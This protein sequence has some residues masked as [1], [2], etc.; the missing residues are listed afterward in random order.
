MRSVRRITRDGAV[1]RLAHYGNRARQAAVNVLETG[2]VSGVRSKHPADF[3]NFVARQAGR[4][5][6]G[7][8]DQWRVNEG[9]RFSSPAKIAVVLNCFYVDLLEELLER[10]TLIPVPFDLFVTNVSG[11]EVEVPQ[12]LGQMANSVVLDCENRGRDIL[13]MI[14]LINSGSLDHY[15]LILKVHTK[16]SPWRAEHAVLQGSGEQWRNSFLEELLPSTEG[17]KTILAAF[18]QDSNLGL[19]TASGNIVGPEHWGGDQRIVEQ[20]LRRIELSVRPDE[21]RFPG[22]SMYWCRGFVLQGLRSLNLIRQDFDEEAGQIDGTTAHAVE[23]IIGIL[24]SEAGL[25][26]TYPSELDPQVSPDQGLDCW[27]PGTEMGARA[28]VV[29]FYLPQFHPSEHNNV[30]WG[31]GFT[32][33][34]NVAGAAPNYAG[35]YQPRIPTELGFYDLRLDEVRHKQL[36]LARQHCVAGFMYYYYW[37]S[38]E[39][40]L[41]VPIE[42]L[43]ADKDLD[44]PFCLMWANENWT[45]RWDG[46]SADVLIGQDYERVPAEDFIDDVM[47]F[48]LDPRYMRVEG[49]AVLAVYRPGQMSNFGEVALEW[50]RRAKQA[51]VGELLLLSVDVAK[52]FDAID[53]QSRG[54]VDGILEFP[55]H[56]LPWRVGP[57]MEA[58]LDKRWR[59]NFMSYQATAQASI[60][61]A[62]EIPDTYYPGAMVSFDNTARRQWHP[63]VWYGSNPYTFRRWVGSQ[64]QVLAARP[65]E[66]RLLFI[67]A[68]N[69]WAESAVLEPTTRYGRTFLLAIR[70]AVWE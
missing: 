53:E 63:D 52:D 26:M 57:T 69:E 18:A 50:R 45:R 68:W 15:S 56:G 17:V 33:W 10:L 9:L 14:S 35:H 6:S 51:G 30:W 7:F 16:K 64:A 24:T 66:Q 36:E 11:Q 2:T 12:E 46:R 70:D 38:G 3:V 44:Q 62:L 55:P 49:K 40:L 42:H 28:T 27:L 65:R 8:P 25:E 32:E 67:N 41:H 5:P 19:V 4:A 22:G 43:L 13:P 48:L 58:G 61:R 31:E 39:R 60:D 59:G 21:L 29:P 47:E 34:S 23:R 20:L 54:Q 37:F 1:R